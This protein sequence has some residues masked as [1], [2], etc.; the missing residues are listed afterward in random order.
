MRESTRA[1][2]DRGAA[3]VEFALILPVL[4]LF[5]FGIIDF[6]RAYWAKITVTEAAR[7][8]VRTVALTP[9]GSDPS[10]KGKNIGAQ[11]ANPLTVTVSPTSTCDSGQPEAS[12][13][14]T[15]QFSSATLFTALNGPI[16][17]TAVMQCPG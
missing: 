13:T 16:S 6:G 15:Y 9:D 7:E 5:V 10:G 11:A 12:V 8:A 17:G 1:K 2:C 3:A 14:V 4:M